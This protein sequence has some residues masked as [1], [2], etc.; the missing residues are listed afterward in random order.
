VDVEPRRYRLRIVN[1]SQS[2]SYNLQFANEKTGTALPF[3]QI[4]AEGGLLRAPVP[5]SALLIAPGERADV[6][7][8]FA[9]QRDPPTRTRS[10]CTW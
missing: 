1:G 2:R 9:D 6:I 8:D 5:M 7:V 10:I 4:G 3:A